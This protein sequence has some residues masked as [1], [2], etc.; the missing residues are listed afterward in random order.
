MR[1]G[2]VGGGPA[3]LFFGYLLKRR[4]PNYTVRIIERNA[5]DATFGFGVVF[6]DRAL[7]FIEKGDPE[8]YRIIRTAMETWPQLTIVLNEERVPID[9]N[10]FAAVG[11]LDLL[12]IL[13]K[14]CLDTGVDIKF[15]TAFS[16]L[17]ELE[18]CDLIVGA[19]GV[20]SRVRDELAE[21]FQPTI[22]YRPNKFAWYGTRQLFDSLTL[23]FRN[24]GAGAFVGHHYRYSGEMSTFIVECDAASW[25]ATGLDQMTDAE[26]QAHCEQV[27][28]ADL[29]G[30]GLISNNSIWRNFPDVTNRHWTIGNVVLIGDAL[31]TAHFSRGSGT[32]LAMEDAI[33]LYHVFGEEPG[34]VAEALSTFETRR[35]PIVDK[36]LAAA[37]NSYMWYEAF[38]DH[39]GQDAYQF[40]YD[41]MTRSGRIDDERLQASAPEFIRQLKARQ[42][43][44]NAGK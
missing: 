42:A 37:R 22:D 34:T 24:H 31:R 41:Y 19:D 26:R 20:N 9:G 32:R 33:E 18:D 39:M 8:T 25:T 38:A 5:A 29:G 40:A 12:R 28:A 14:R 1:V 2:I 16:S 10:E 6:S 44:T 43:K 13:Q 4:F 36:I 11:R 27:F 30:H 17:D 23:T 7:S 21:K 3:G 15:E 35:R